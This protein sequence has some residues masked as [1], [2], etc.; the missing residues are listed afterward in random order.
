MFRKLTVILAITFMALAYGGAKAQ[1]VIDSEARATATQAQENAA[2]A[3][4]GVSDVSGG[5]VA[6]QQVVADLQT[7]IDALQAAIGPGAVSAVS[8]DCTMGETIADAVA[9]AT[10]GTPLTV[11]F[12]GTCMENV[13]IDVN[14]IT[15]AGLDPSTSIVQGQITVISAGRVVI[16]NAT[17][18]QSSS[19]GVFVTRGASATLRNVAITNNTGDG[20]F[21]NRNSEASIE[22][23]FIG[24]DASGDV[25]GNA[26]GDWG[27]VIADDGHVRLTNVNV[28]A[29]ENNQEAAIGLFRDTSIR[30]RGQSLISN[31][32]GGLAL[33][34]QHNSTLR[35][36]GPSGTGLKVEG[37]VRGTDLSSLEFRNTVLESDVVAIDFVRIA[38][39]VTTL[40]GKVLLARDSLLS[41]VGSDNQVFTVNGNVECATSQSGLGFINL[42]DV[43]KFNSGLDIT[44]AI[45]NCTILPRFTTGDF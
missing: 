13:S 44:G 39:R 24:T 12:E 6:L 4:Q 33:D 38:G 11:T 29:N 40:N 43:T 9:L 30:I 10:P 23:S 8:V 5:L 19:S 17:V 42:D 36:D 31:A 7:Q 45:T 37:I 16:E 18:T 34:I 3:E 25:A 1:E 32:A 35:M 26:N 28:G 41:H 27:V 14:D 22:D 15:L 2:L 20:V 21:V